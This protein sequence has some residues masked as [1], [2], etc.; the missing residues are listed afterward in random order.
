MNAPAV[1]DTVV[2]VRC[3]F[4]LRSLVAI[5]ACDSRCDESGHACGLLPLLELFSDRNQLKNYRAAATIEQ[6]SG[7]VADGEPSTA[8]SEAIPST[9][10]AKGGSIPPGPATPGDGDA[11]MLYG[12]EDGCDFVLV[13]SR[14]GLRAG[15]FEL[16]FGGAYPSESDLNEAERDELKWYMDRFE[17]EDTWSCGGTQWHMEVGEIGH[18]AAIKFPAKLLTEVSAK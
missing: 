14:E 16:I 9:G 12:W 1:V 18:V 17:D 15:M 2:N 4:C 10:D 3:N 11:W 5:T 13:R 8:R 6:R 7:N